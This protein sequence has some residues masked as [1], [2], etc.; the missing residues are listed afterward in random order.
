[1]RYVHVNGIRLAYELRVPGS[2]APEE[3]DGVLL[4]MGFQA[5]GEAWLGQAE[6][7]HKHH[8]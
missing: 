1:M 8:R 5:R 4:I 2:G 7:F 3:R 6:R